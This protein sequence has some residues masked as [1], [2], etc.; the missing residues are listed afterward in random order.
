MFVLIKM[1]MFDLN[2][3]FTQPDDRFSLVAYITCKESS[4]RNFSN[5]A[6][7][8]TFLLNVNIDE[9]AKTS[10]SHIYTFLRTTFIRHTSLGIVHVNYATLCVSRAGKNGDSPKAVAAA[11]SSPESWWSSQTDLLAEEGSSS[12]CLFE[13][14]MFVLVRIAMH[15]IWTRVV[16]S[17]AAALRCF[18]F[19]G[20]S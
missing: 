13:T 2:A 17:E 18:F 7:E 6:P 19:L 20:K 16:V 10:S 4:N 1:K 15:T 8:N 5:N 12:C 14:Q 9:I 11:L 3:L